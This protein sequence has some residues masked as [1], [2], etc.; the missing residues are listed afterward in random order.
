M[1]RILYSLESSGSLR[2]DLITEPPWLPV[3]PMTVMS[4]AWVMVLVV[5]FDD[6]QSSAFKEAT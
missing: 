5:G 2:I 4:L 6:I 3:E 1:P